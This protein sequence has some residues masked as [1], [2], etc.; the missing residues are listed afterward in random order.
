M[1]LKQEETKLLLRKFLCY[2]ISKTTLCSQSAYVHLFAEQAIFYDIS[3][4]NASISG[5]S[6]TVLRQ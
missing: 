3:Q 6:I 2:C 1:L 4:V 5:V